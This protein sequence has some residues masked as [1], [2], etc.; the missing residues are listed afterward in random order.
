MPQKAGGFSPKSQRKTR[1]LLADG[2][3]VV[4]IGGETLDFDRAGTGSRQALL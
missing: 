4:G 1:Q 2:K 3:F